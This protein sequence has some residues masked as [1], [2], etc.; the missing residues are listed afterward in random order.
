VHCVLV[1]DLSLLVLGCKLAAVAVVAKVVAAVVAAVVAK[2]VVADVAAAVAKV[3]EAASI[4]QPDVPLVF[5]DTIV[6]AVVGIVALVV[7]AVVEVV[8]VGRYHAQLIACLLQ[9]QSTALNIVTVA[10]IW[11]TD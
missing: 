6:V 4:H 2:V 5:V 8:D 3:V 7:V 9:H 1:V 10:A 11:T